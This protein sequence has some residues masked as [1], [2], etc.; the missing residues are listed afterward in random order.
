MR[1]DQGQ[2]AVADDRD[3]LPRPGTA[4][5]D[6]PPGHGGG[7]GQRRLEQTGRTPEHVYHLGREQH[8]VG[9]GPGPGEA[10]L[11]VDHA[12][13]R[14][15]LHALRADPVR[16]D[17]LGDHRL[18]GFQA[19]HARADRLDHA[20]PLVPGDQRVADVGRIDHAGQQLEIGA[21]DP[22]VHRPG[23]HLTG[24]GDQLRGVPQGDRAGRGDDQGAPVSHGVSHGRAP[25]RW[26]RRGPR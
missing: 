11:V 20:R 2:R 6:G 23:H 8:L 16:D 17:A 7:L 9:G 14:M 19:G 21:A 18:A 4:A 24:T 22:G 25:R 13:V 15:A 10:E 5:A 1:G 3:P 26:D 12:Q